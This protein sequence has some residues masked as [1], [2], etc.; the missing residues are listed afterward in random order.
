LSLRKGKIFFG[1]FKARQLVLVFV[2]VLVLVLVLGAVV[3]GAAAWERAPEPF[4]VTGDF[5]FQTPKYVSAA[6]R[7]PSMA[8]FLRAVSGADGSGDANLRERGAGS[9]EAYLERYL[10]EVEA[11]ETV[12]DALRT[13]MS[14]AV[15]AAKL[16]VEA[17]VAGG[18]AP[19]EMAS[20]LLSAP[21]WPWRVALLR[22]ADGA[23]E[24][25]MPHTVHDVIVLPRARVARSPESEL[26][27]LLVH[28]ATHVYQRMRRAQAHAVL[29]R[30]FGLVR[31][32]RADGAGSGSSRRKGV[33]ANPDTDDR[34]WAAE[35]P[36]GG[37]GGLILFPLPVFQGRGFRD[38]ELEPARGGAD[39]FEMP[40]E[41]PY[42]VM[43]YAWQKAAEKHVGGMGRVGGVGRVGRVGGVGRVGVS[44]VAGVAGGAG[45]GPSDD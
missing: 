21:V 7:A 30:D 2:L 25:G 6:L 23:V 8:W 27:S 1:M 24:G 17:A 31:L 34:D 44:G 19:P 20:G 14:G 10:S 26:A 35:A 36:S 33:R 11:P 41:H 32:S 39:G 42:E 12:E 40:G 5:S 28:E 9:T 15:R 37:V 43:A 16:A 3:V 4:A 13:K 22:D 29:R 18:D 45:P 38:V